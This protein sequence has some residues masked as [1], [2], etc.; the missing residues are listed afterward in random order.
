LERPIY[1]S[2]RVALDDG[3]PPGST[4]VIESVCM[5]Q[6]RAE[7][8]VDSKGRFS[9]QFGQKNNGM[10]MDASTGSRDVFGEMPSGMSS[11]ASGSASGAMGM[12][13]D[14]NRVRTCEV[15]ARL[16]GY[17]SDVIPLV[18]HN[19]MDHPD[20]GLI[21][22]HRLGG[23]V[24]GILVSA[25]SLAAPKDARKAFEKG[26][27]ALKNNKLEDA[28]KNFEK[29]TQTY[30]NYAAAWCELGKMQ[31]RQRQVEQARQSFEAA[32]RADSKFLEPYLYLSTLL[33][34]AQ[35][36]DQLAATTGK[37]LKLDPYDYPQAY[38]YNAVALY[39]KNDLETAEKSAREAQKLDTRKQFPR[40]WALLA[41]IL[42]NRH[43]YAGAA[44][45]MGDYLKMA[46]QAPDA[47]QARA[48]LAQYERLAAAA[49]TQAQQKQ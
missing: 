46:P 9:F 31:G 4:I 49:P 38:F 47:V 42:A 24:E 15:Q 12:S 27:E 3:V 17:R 20:I 35:Q 48:D 11:H 13:S 2:G 29:A 21:M 22:L 36:W 37:A 7:G 32:I 25:T 28:L 18:G 39:Y 33:A 40:S 43:D 5:G 44:Q 6:A 41:V 14:M 8:Y 30:P 19:P 26:Q 16:P 23:P 34:G 1:I 45:Q 10:M